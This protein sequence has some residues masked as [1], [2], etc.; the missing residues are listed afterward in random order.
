MDR[1]RRGRCVTVEKR[2]VLEMSSQ[3]LANKKL[4]PLFYRKCYA[5]WD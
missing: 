1:E 3:K 2:S 4:Q 5:R